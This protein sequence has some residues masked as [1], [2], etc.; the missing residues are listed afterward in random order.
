VPCTQELQP[1]STLW[2]AQIT[3]RRLVMALIGSSGCT[4]DP[5]QRSGSDE[6]CRIVAGRRQ[7]SHA[8]LKV[9]WGS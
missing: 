9:T 8:W 7:H 2:P 6:T 5:V 4:D 1:V 3:M